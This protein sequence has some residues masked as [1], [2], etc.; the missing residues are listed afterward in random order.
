[1]QIIS[2]VSG[3][4]TDLSFHAV[5]Y[6]WQIINC[7]LT[8]SYSVINLVDTVCHY[9]AA[10]AYGLVGRCSNC[11]CGF[12]SCYQSHTHRDGFFL[13]GGARCHVR[14]RGVMLPITKKKEE[15][16]EKRKL[17][18][19]FFPISELASLPSFFLFLRNHGSFPYRR[20]MPYH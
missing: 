20:D 4:I 6:T 13:G 19:F 18:F 15:Q 7:F 14:G 2:A 11:G 12:V 9:S 16:R 1:M 17:L 8:A 10:R 5:G 3:G